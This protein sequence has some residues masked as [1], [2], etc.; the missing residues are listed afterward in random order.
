MFSHEAK[1]INSKSMSQIIKVDYAAN[2]QVLVG[3]FYLAD[4]IATWV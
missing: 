4:I 1:Q 2:V 3:E